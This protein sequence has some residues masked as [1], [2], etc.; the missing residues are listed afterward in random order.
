M[1]LH[2][3][4]LFL[5]LFGCGVFM[6]LKRSFCLHLIYNYNL[7]NNI[8]NTYTKQYFFLSFFSQ[9]DLKKICCKSIYVCCPSINCSKGYHKTLPLWFGNDF[10]GDRKIVKLQK[11]VSVWII[12]QFCWVQGRELSESSAPSSV[13]PPKTKNNK[14]RNTLSD[15][16][17][18]ASLSAQRRKESRGWRGPAR[19]H[20]EGT[21]IE[22]ELGHR[23]GEVGHPDWNEPNGTENVSPRWT[24]PSTISPP[25]FNKVPF[26]LRDME[27]TGPRKRLEGCWDCGEHINFSNLSS[28]IKASGFIFQRRLTTILLPI[29]SPV[30]KVGLN[31]FGPA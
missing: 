20:T 11:K 8:L 10:T 30:Q 24:R 21:R 15:P 1:W 17:Q 22:S 14:R 12:L 18:Q 29:Q 4:T 19:A 3:E 9:T 7:K 25:N 23:V 13:A 6:E 2:Q 28:N 5:M 31:L 16:P 26:Q 27:A